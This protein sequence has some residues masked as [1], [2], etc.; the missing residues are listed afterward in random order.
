MKRRKFF[1]TASYG[2][3]GLVVT[4]ACNP[5]KKDSNSTDT[6]PGTNQVKEEIPAYRRLVKSN[7]PDEKTRS[8]GNSLVIALIG[9]G[10][11]GTNIIIEAAGLKENIRVK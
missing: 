5:F 8:A 2:A 3:A 6:G 11:W 10:S 9:A 7:F 1:R 4:A